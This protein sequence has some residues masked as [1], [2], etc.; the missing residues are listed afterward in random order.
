MPRRKKVDNK[1]FLKLYRQGKSNEQIAA[2]MGWKAPK[3]SKDRFYRVRAQKSV[4]SIIV[5]AQGRAWRR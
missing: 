4:V 1:L 5:P 3:K 2:V